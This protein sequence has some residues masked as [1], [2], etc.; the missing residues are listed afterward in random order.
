M[1]TN[2]YIACLRQVVAFAPK[3]IN[4]CLPPAG[5]RI[6]SQGNYYCLSPT[7]GRI[8]SQDNY[9]CLPPAGVL[10]SQNKV[11][12]CAVYGVAQARGWRYGWIG[13]RMDGYKGVYRFSSL[14]KQKIKAKNYAVF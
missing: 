1:D 4:Y 7:G 9:Y 6:R 5:G 13:G 10:H 8:R 11:I 14:M 2:I 3:V 12:K